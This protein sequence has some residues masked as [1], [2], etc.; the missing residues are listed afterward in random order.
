MYGG[1]NDTKCRQDEHA[2]VH[3][4]IYVTKCRISSRVTFWMFS[5][6]CLPSQKVQF[7]ADLRRSSSPV[8]VGTFFFFNLRKKT[9]IY[10]YIISDEKKKLGF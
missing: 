7:W 2:H 9:N 6:I 5:F 8:V 3:K 1:T 10:I 4:S